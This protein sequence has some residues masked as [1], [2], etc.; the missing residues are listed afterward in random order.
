M[1]SKWYQMYIHTAC[2]PRWINFNK[3]RRDVGRSKKTLQDTFLVCLIAILDVE[4]KMLICLFPASIIGTRFPLSNNY[5]AQFRNLLMNSLK[6]D[7]VP[8]S[9]IKNLW[10]LAKILKFVL[11]PKVV[12][13]N[14]LCYHEVISIFGAFVSKVLR[15]EGE[16]LY[17]LY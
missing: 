4:E 17:N 15:R 3:L 6:C 9:A 10:M 8:I 16:H 1:M 14:W 12:I 13:I 2:V 7:E 5:S 11:S